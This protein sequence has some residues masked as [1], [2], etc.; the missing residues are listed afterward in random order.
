MRARLRTWLCVAGAG[1][2]GLGA[3]AYSAARTLE[4]PAAPTPAAAADE[5]SRLRVW[6]AQGFLPEENEAILSLFDRWKRE[7]GH[8]VDVRF[9]P[10]NEMDAELLRALDQGTPPDLF[11][12]TV[13]DMRLI[14]ILAWRNQL[15]DVSDVIEPRKGEFI[16]TALEASYLKN[17]VT[18]QRACYAVPFGQQVSYIHY[19][20]DQLASA[21]LGDR[22]IPTGWSEYWQFWKV[23][24]DRLRAQGRDGVHGLGLSVSPMDVDS[25]NTFEQFLEAHDA[26]IV[27]P[28]GTLLLD[29]PGTR[30]K[31]VAVIREYAAFY[32]EGYVPRDAVQ[33]TSA[34]NN[35]SFLEGRLL[36]TINGSLS[37]PL[38][39]K[40]E[41]NEYNNAAR[42]LY[43]DRMV[44]SGWPNKPSGGPIRM[45]VGIKQIVAFER[46]RNKE[47]AK[48]F[49]RFLLNPENLNLLLRVGGKG[50][51]LPVTTELLADPYW[52]DPEDP[53]LSSALRLALGPTRP[54]YEAY[55]AAYTDVQFQNVWAKALLQVLE[56]KASAEQA[57]DWAIA[58][59]KDTFQK[60]D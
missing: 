57:A 56:S 12:S 5:S 24:Q 25:F 60:W 51:Y 8:D 42:E 13:G 29:A 59:I 28:D 48:S 2:L 39:Q 41:P 10:V 53:H 49:L 32:K 1:V 11:H 16:P 40:L 26:P 44:T 34:G 52:S 9:M 47:A 31:I 45:I 54:G 33:W 30:D 4:P 22:P 38:T 19:W 23:A 37:I 27:S 50:R 46:S 6:W 7:V 15:A 36:M 17:K 43:F 3:A 55:S 21:G 58:S 18:K 20:R 14:P 35:I